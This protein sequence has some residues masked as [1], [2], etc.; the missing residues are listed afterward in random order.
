MFIALYMLPLDELCTK[1]GL[2]YHIYADD[3]QLYIVF[4]ATD[5]SENANAN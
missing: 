2:K 3:I 1:H 5:K 4:S